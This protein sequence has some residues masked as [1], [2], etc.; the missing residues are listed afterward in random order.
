MFPSRSL[1]QTIILNSHGLAA[2]LLLFLYALSSTTLTYLISFAFTNPGAGVVVLYGRMRGFSGAD[3]LFRAVGCV[4][5]RRRA[6]WLS[7]TV[8]AVSCCTGSS[9][10]SWTW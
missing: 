7:C 4:Q 10:L 6:V 5:C 8:W 3:W 2:F 9:S 1:A